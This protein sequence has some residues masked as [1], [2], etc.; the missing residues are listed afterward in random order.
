MTDALSPT[1]GATAGGAGTRRA[2]LLKGAGVVVALVAVAALAPV[3]FLEWLPATDPTVIERRV[4][5][6]GVRLVYANLACCGPDF[7]RWDAVVQG[8]RSGD[9]RWLRL[10]VAFMPVRDAHPAE[11]L[12]AAVAAAFE[13][14]PAA[15]VRILVPAYTA[16]VV[17]GGEQTEERVD[18]FRA[19]ARLATLETVRAPSLHL[20]SCR[21]VLRRIAATVRHGA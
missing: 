17:C 2:R 9:P 6:L 13:A 5:W 18:A 19:Q 7:R 8:V 3:A 1:S 20:D 11:E 16:A 10:A 21:A 12:D 4:R 14:D 15:A